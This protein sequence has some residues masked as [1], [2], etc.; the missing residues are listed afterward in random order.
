MGV[1]NDGNGRACPSF[2]RCKL[3]GVPLATFEGFY[4]GSLV[5]TG[6]RRH[7]PVPLQQHRQVQ[8]NHLVCAVGVV[9][10]DTDA[11]CMQFV[12][13][14]WDKGALLSEIA[15]PRELRHVAPEQVHDRSTPHVEPDTKV[16]P[17]AKRMTNILNNI[18]CAQKKHL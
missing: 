1:V 2:T 11:N 4:A 12:V 3:P 8:R 13:M 10:A 7:A 16:G 18:N 9:I 5:T 17:G 14:Q 6:R 15:S